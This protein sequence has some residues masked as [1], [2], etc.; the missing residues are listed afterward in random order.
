MEL[1]ASDAPTTT[2]VTGVQKSAKIWYTL[3]DEA[4][5]LATHAFLPIVRRFLAPNGVA[6]EA[7]DISLANRVLS[8]WPDKLSASQR[9][10][11]V[12]AKLG[13]IAK[14]P[15]ANIV[16][17]PNVS[18]SVPQLESVIAELNAKGF[19]VPKYPKGDFG[20]LTEHERDIKTRYGGVLGSAV[21]PVLREGNSDRRVAA[22][23]KQFAQS[24][25]HK[26]GTWSPDSKTH[27][28]SMPSGDFY[29]SE[30][31]SVMQSSGSLRVE[32][33]PANGTDA[34]IVLKEG[35]AVEARETIDASSMSI[36]DL[37]AFIEHE[38]QLAATQGVLVSL[39]LKATMMK[40]SDPV[41]FGRV[42]SVYFKR[43]FEKHASAL[44]RIG[45][46][47]EHG[48]GA[49]LESVRGI[50]DVAEKQ[51]ILD[52]ITACYSQNDRPRVA[53]VD[54]GKGVTNFHVP[55]DVIVDASMPAM[56]REGGRMW[57]SGNEPEDTKCLIPDRSYALIFQACIDDCK[58]HGQ[59]DV[60]TMGSVA[61]VGLMARA[62]EEY[63][64][65]DKTFK[66]T[67]DGAVKVFFIPE[68]GT[69][70]STPMFTHQVTAGD[71]WRMCQTKD[72]AVRDWVRLAVTR[73]TLSQSPAVF[74][75]D[76]KRAHDAELRTQVKRYLE[77]DHV[78]VLTETLLD[79]S[80][81][82]DIMS[83]TDAINHCM[84]RARDGKDTISVTGN[85]LRDYLTDLFPI[86][87]LGTSAKVRVVFPKSKVCFPKQD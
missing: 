45:A 68:G 29:G 73:A 65:H 79:G 35:I 22:P 21:N 24:N 23:V 43:A 13:E 54:S 69:K 4:P 67:E 44:A 87:E 2:E 50:P 33:H 37:D 48:L 12:L 46:N 84:R 78:S 55:S 1:A 38:L 74:W 16:K 52:D 40:I 71:L 42:V 19:P 70:S 80:K 58:K 11:D 72:A 9:R 25:P 7:A 63:G 3:T 76:P 57:N 20:T 81:L 51:R 85:V 10:P 39:H 49:V 18:A 8:A 77:M 14:T 66:A 62:A 53:M 60:A 59:F 61:N 75:L 30:K 28:S 36:S 31:T 34:P 83:P 32:L 6:V 26:M 47:P 17:L 64:S 27:V 5:A 86:I 15:R 82:I 56:I 41:L